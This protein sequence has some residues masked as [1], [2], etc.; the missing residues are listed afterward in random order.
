MAFY[1]DGH[2]L[3]FPKIKIPSPLK[4]VKKLAKK[5]LPF[6]P[7]VGAGIEAVPISPAGGTGWRMAAR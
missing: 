3:G 4:A 7:V 5:A 2:G 1:E 6:V